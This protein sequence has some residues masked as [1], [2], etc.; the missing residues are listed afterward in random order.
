M[1][2]PATL[3]RKSLESQLAAAA[4]A[5]VDGSETERE[6]R[7]GRVRLIVQ[8]ANLERV[9]GLVI[10]HDALETAERAEVGT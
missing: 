8:A 6:T 3:A 9:R 4:V 1:T 5:L 2:T 10:A 7:D